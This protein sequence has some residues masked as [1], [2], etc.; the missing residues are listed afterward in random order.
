MKREWIAPLLILVALAISL[1]VVG[2]LPEQVPTHW[3][4]NGE[5]DGWMGPWGASLAG[6]V[7]MAVVWGLMLLPARIDPR[8]KN[9]VGSWPVYLLLMNGVVAFLGLIHLLVLSYALGLGLD[10]MDSVFLLI[11]ALFLV[12]SYSLP[13]VRP[14]WWVGIRTPWTL[15]SERVWRETHRLGAWTFAI[16]G[17]LAI[18]SAVLP[19]PLAHRV[20]YTAVFAG[21]LIPVIASYFFWKRAG[22]TDLRI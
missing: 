14:N 18:L 2:R 7:I 15:T 1:T 9:F 5:V 6:P 13:R 3:N 4:Y 20:F 21:P 19:H 22:L 10:I 17:V 8:R 12:L 16:G 11:G